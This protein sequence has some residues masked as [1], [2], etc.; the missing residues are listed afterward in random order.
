MIVAGG[1]NAGLCAAMAA[2]DEGAS[3]L[4]LERSPKWRRG[5]NSRHTRDIRYA[6]ELPDKWATAPYPPA[7]FLADL[8][9]VAGTLPN[10]ELASL[11]IE[12]SQELPEWMEA[13]GCRWQHPMNGTLHLHTNRFFL[14]GGKAMINS[15]YDTARARGI[16][17]RT[18][19]TVDSL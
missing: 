2:R 7:E 19:T 8:E 13:H 16:D 6:H 1:G 11:L 3:V 12:R 4:L 9:A 5:G 18:E 10:P 17:V 14:G 15:Y